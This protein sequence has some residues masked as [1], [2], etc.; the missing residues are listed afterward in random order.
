MV[1]VLAREMNLEILTWNDAHVDYVDNSASFQIGGGA[2]EYLPYQSQLASF[3][4]F[5]N[6]GG[7]GMDSLDVAGLD[8]GGGGGGKSSKSGRTSLTSEKDGEYEGSVILI[9]EVSRCSIS[10]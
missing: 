6:A 5:L 9:E 10:F 8:S 2:G 7:L 4:E 1:K 3:E